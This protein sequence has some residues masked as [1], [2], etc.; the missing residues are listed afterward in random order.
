[1]LLRDLAE[2]DFSRMSDRAI[3]AR[4]RIETAR[5]EDS[6]PGGQVSNA[7]MVEMQLLAHQDRCVCCGEY[8][9]GLIQCPACGTK[10]E[11]KR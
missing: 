2:Q 10:V 7:M 3:A 9:A 8:I 4:V 1:M 5:D 6:L 11:A